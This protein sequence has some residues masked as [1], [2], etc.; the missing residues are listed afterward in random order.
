MLK[1]PKV[2]FSRDNRSTERAFL[3]L[4]NIL[5]EIANSTLREKD[6]DSPGPIP[7]PREVKDQE[8]RQDNAETT[9]DK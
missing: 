1:A 3:L 7:N 4:G 2:A 9:E 6:P 8:N 5:A